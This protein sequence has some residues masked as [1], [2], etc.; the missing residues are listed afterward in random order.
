MVELGPV[1]SCVHLEPVPVETL[2]GELV[3]WLC[4][5]CDEALPANWHPLPP[6]LPPFV[7]DPRLT[8]YVG[9]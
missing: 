1:T 9:I 8:I 4:P 3:A 7:P 5:E 6:E 2:D